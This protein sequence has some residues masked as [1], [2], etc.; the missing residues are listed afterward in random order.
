MLREGRVK[1]QLQGGGFAVGFSDREVTVWGGLALMK[2]MLD[3]LQFREAFPQFGVP[4]ASSNRGSVPCQLI[5]Q[6]I[7]SIWCGACRFAHA[8]VVRL[9][10]VLCRL[11]GWSCAAGH[12]SAACGPTPRTYHVVKPKLQII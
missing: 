3:R 2:Q 7:V 1:R 6:F 5:E 9:D 12:G 8:E 10:N 11:F 4:E